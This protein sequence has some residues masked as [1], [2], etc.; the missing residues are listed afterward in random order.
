MGGRED[1]RGG[2]TMF[3]KQENEGEGLVLHSAGWIEALTKVR[4]TKKQRWADR[5]WISMVLAERG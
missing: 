1:G 5:G 3:E 2:P 4:V